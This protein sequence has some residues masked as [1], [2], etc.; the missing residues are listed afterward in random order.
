MLEATGHQHWEKKKKAGGGGKMRMRNP[1]GE[2]GGFSW[3]P[4]GSSSA[5]S[6]SQGGWFL[7]NKFY[8]LYMLWGLGREARAPRA[9]LMAALAKGTL[10]RLREGPQGLP[11]STLSQRH[12]GT[13]SRTGKNGGI[14]CSVIVYWSLALYFNYQGKFT[15]TTAG[16]NM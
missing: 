14:A 15:Y 4:L 5:H 7:H 13:V 1:E 3:G 12:H 16:K 6:A 2:V 11:F 9:P 10:A 8:S